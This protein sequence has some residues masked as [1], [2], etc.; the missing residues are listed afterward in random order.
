MNPVRVD[1]P[2]DESSQQDSR[3]V[4]QLQQTIWDLREGMGTGALL[5]TREETAAV[6]R[7]TPQTI[8]KMME[9][10]RLDAVVLVDDEPPL[11]RPEAILNFLDNS[12]QSARKSRSEM[13]A[14]NE[15]ME[16]ERSAE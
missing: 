13:H 11:F 4:R 16:A 9:E 10:G 14:H 12:S 15:R 2:E 3:K 8:D 6:L 7:T 5:F 1:D